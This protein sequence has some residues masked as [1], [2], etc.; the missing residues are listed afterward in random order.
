MVLNLDDKD[1]II[2]SMYSADPNVSQESIAKVLR[3]S[4]P[5]VASRVGKLRERGALELNAGVSPLKMGLYLAKV[6]L[7]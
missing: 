3:L 1:K 6:D 4:Q 7:S 2:I 5:S